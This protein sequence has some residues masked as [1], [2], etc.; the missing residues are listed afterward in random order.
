LETF[1]SAQLLADRCLNH[2]SVVS[3]SRK[4]GI[5]PFTE[6]GLRAVWGATRPRP[7]WF[8]RVLHDLLQLAKDERTQVIDESFIAPKLESLSSAARAGGGIEELLSEDTRLA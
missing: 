6:G 1:S 7:R 5:Y 4:P 8:L 2:P 3:A